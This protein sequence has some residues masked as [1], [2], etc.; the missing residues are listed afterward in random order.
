VYQ[1]GVQ[2]T[3][4]RT[5]PDVSLVADPATGA[6]IADPY[7]LNP[8]DPFEVVGGTSLS[9]PAWAGL[10]ALADQGRAAVGESAL[11]RTGPAETQQAIYS[12]PQSDY[13]VIESGNNG[14]S[15]NPGYNL[16]TGLGTP[17]AN[18][19]V[20]DLIAYAGP[21]TT[22]PG[23]PVGPLQDA[24]LVSTESSG[25]ATGDVANV[26]DSFTVTSNGRV[27]GNDSS[28]STVRSAGSDLVAVAG[29][30]S[31]GAAISPL[32]ASASGTALSNRAV[33]LTAPIAVSVPIARST[34]PLA[35][36][37]STSPMSTVPTADLS[38]PLLGAQ[39]NWWGSAVPIGQSI[40]PDG[41]AYASS[42]NLVSPLPE[43]DFSGPGHCVWD[44]ILAEWG[45][46]H[47]STAPRTVAKPADVLPPAIAPSPMSERAGTTSRR[48]DTSLR[49]DG[50]VTQEDSQDS[51]AR[52]SVLATSSLI[53]FG[54]RIA[55]RCLG[56]RKPRKVELRPAPGG[57]I[58][59]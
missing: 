41:Q 2:S 40:P 19:L 16:V 17:V 28:P 33:L 7:N 11:N 56:E 50:R 55:F 21:G 51:G 3:G 9:A 29:F 27:F 46:P 22:Y 49:E 6:W 47:T 14:Y 38:V 57:R 26:F 43:R 18:L 54:A 58:K 32:T 34:A 53:V 25:G 42:M 45:S 31:G 23:P 13:H 30:A 36:A 4:Y 8:N 44:T 12:L 48:G 39:N 10:V 20:R 37:A 35:L 1:Q 59:G 52:L 24:N 5:T 15:A